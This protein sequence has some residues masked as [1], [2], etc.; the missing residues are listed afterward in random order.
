LGATIF[1]SRDLRRFSRILFA[2]IAALI[3]TLT[4]VNLDHLS[5]IF[6]L[7]VCALSLIATVFSTSIVPTNADS[8]ELR[9][10]SKPVYFILL[11]AFWSSMMLAVMSSSFIGLWAGISATTL[12]TTFL[13]GFSGGKAALEAAWKYL[14]LCSFGIGIALIGMLLL[15]RAAL[16]AGIA[17]HDALAWNAIASHAHHLA[18]PLTRVALV[19]MIIGFATK[20]GLVPMHSW[21]PDAHSKAPAPVS[22]VLS[23]LLVSCALY[24]LIRV[25]S[26]AAMSDVGHRINGTLLLLGSASVLLAGLLMLAQQDVKRLLSYSTVEHSGLVAIALGCASPI[27][28]FAAL[29]HILNH[30]FTKSLA[31]LSVGII[32]H[33]TG[34]T[35]ISEL[36]GLWR[37]ST[38]GKFLLAAL[39]ALAGLPPFG[40]FFSE[41]LIV[42]ACIAAKEWIPLVC[43]LLGMLVAFAA[44]CR[45]AIN[46]ESGSATTTIDFRIPRIAITVTGVALCGALLLAIAPFL[47]IGQALYHVAAMLGLS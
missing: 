28:Y 22:A 25:Q 44:L 1:R 15:G 31:F 23:G 17:P 7:V 39:V 2:V 13:V 4:A 47:N 16:D 32:A 34:T 38:S 37:S 42:T 11:G 19:L 12:A 40:L 3:G 29:Y 26:V 18:N 36:H 21:L 43:A 45:L 33:K 20:A 9:W 10:S 14:I 30:A 5:A 24:A 41:L 6:V 35:S 46:T 27:G 8:S